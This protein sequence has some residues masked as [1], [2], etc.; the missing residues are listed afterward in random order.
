VWKDVTD[1]QVGEV[2]DAVEAGLPGGGKYAPSRRGARNGR[3]VGNVVIEK[4]GVDEAQAQRMV[5]Q[6]LR[7]GLLFESRERD[8]DSR[9]DVVV[10]VVNHAKRPGARG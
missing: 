6:W 4:L 10:V 3:W 2:L 5:A 7:S 8:A 9:K 1:E